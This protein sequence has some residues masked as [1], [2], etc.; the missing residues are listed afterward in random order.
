M[1]FSPNS[2]IILQHPAIGWKSPKIH[3]AGGLP[4]CVFVGSEK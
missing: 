1:I 2:P 3:P 4:P